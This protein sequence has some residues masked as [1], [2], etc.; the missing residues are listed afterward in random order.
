MFA[1]LVVAFLVA[2]KS[3]M[4]K[5]HVLAKAVTLQAHSQQ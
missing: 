3:L 5:S 2:K 4:Q 1:F